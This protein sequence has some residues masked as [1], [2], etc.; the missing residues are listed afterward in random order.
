MHASKLTSSD[1]FGM[2]G[3]T[4]DV[5]VHEDV[6]PEYEFP[7]L[8]IPRQPAG[9][10]GLASEGLSWAA[11]F[12]PEGGIRF[13]PATV[14]YQDLYL[15]NRFGDDS[16][17]LGGLPADLKAGDRLEIEIA[18]APH[19]T[20]MSWDGERRQ[21]NGRLEWDLATDVRQVMATRGGVTQTF[22]VLF[23]RA[24]L[25]AV[26]GDVDA[27]R[28][29]IP[30]PP[31]EI[32]VPGNPGPNDSAGVNYMATYPATHY[33][34]NVDLAYDQVT[35]KAKVTASAKGYIPESRVSRGL[36]G[37][38]G[39]WHVRLHG[40]VYRRANGALPAAPAARTSM[41]T[42]VPAVAGVLEDGVVRELTLAAG[43]TL[44][45]G[46]GLPDGALVTSRSGPGAGGGPPESQTGFAAGTRARELR[47]AAD[48]VP[49]Q[50]EVK[51]LTFDQGR[52]GMRVDPDYQGSG[53][54]AI[55]NVRNRSEDRELAGA[56]AFPY[57][58]VDGDLIKLDRARLRDLRMV[59]LFSTFGLTST[60]YNIAAGS[61]AFEGVRQTGANA[62]DVGA[63]IEA[64]YDLGAEREAFLTINHY[65][66]ELGEG[67]Y[68]SLQVTDDDDNLIAAQPIGYAVAPPG[69][70]RTVGGELIDH[71]RDITITGAAAETHS[72]QIGEVAVN[73][74]T[75]GADGNPARLRI[76]RPDSPIETDP[77][78][79]PAAALGAGRAVMILTPRAGKLST[80][81]GFGFRLDPRADT[82]PEPPPI[83]QQC[84]PL[85]VTDPSGD[86]IAGGP[87]VVA[88]WFTS[89]AD[90]IYATMQFAALP[91]APRT[92]A[93]TTFSMTWRD[94]H[95]GHHASALLDATGWKFDDGP[96]NVGAHPT[97]GTSSPA[98]GVVDH[99]RGL[100][101]I[102]VPRKVLNSL[103][104]RDVAVRSVTR[105]PVLGA[106]QDDI[107]PDGSRSVFGLGGDW[108][109]GSCGT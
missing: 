33:F 71:E 6:S 51:D 102:T 100:I 64:I 72:L 97:V 39:E 26:G 54:L 59:P 37:D 11:W 21:A 45:T 94:G 14:T 77:A 84:R 32:T 25:R 2:L 4:V 49:E 89:D 28:A 93:T 47:D 73:A 91:T 13:E 42:P 79:D 66:G 53:V 78:V 22:D 8:R 82:N 56:I 88:G 55:E 5:D 105:L 87:D 41:T 74:S 98:E 99:A 19:N 44:L 81:A 15:Y 90:N 18:N 101:R 61:G 10:G 48:I 27:R 1:S 20:A 57:V 62:E 86:A 65:S 104:I 70:I 34:S 80:S 58:R 85:P 24:D 106:Q 83:E 31:L 38:V 12:S 67:V 29:D 50:T 36:G 107:G 40:A 52:R 103:L 108:L 46:P 17:V 16:N 43:D 3:Y 92:G 63:A 60:G 95:N 30:A 76:L 23:Y 69:A 75:T 35:R 109:V 9:E 7:R 68:A 96:H